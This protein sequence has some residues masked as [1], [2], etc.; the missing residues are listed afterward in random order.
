[1][2]AII[3]GLALFAASGTALARA[4]EPASTPVIVIHAGQLLATAGEPVRD[5][6]TIVVRDGKIVKVVPGFR[7]PTDFDPKA[8]L[9]DLSR[10]FVMAGLSDMHFHFV[11]GDDDNRRSWTLAQRI[12]RL[13]LNAERQARDMLAVG[14]TSVRDVG[15]NTNAVTFQLRDAIDSGKVEGPRLFAAGRLI[16][17]SEGHGAERRAGLSLLSDEPLGGCDGVD[18][19]RRVVRENIGD[20]HG[21]DLIKFTGSGSASE[22]TGARDALPTSSDEEVMAIVDS[23]RRLGRSVAVHAHSTASIDQSLRAGA[24]TIEHGTFFD[25]ETAKLFRLH[26]AFLVPTSFVGDLMLTDPRIK[27]RNTP[28]DWKRIQIIAV[29]QRAN[30]GRGYRAGIRL[31]VGTDS[32]SGL[33]PRNTL[34]EI[35]IFVEDG[36]PVVEALKAATLNNAII[37]GHGVDLGQIKEGFLAD[38]VA[39][40]QSPLQDI[41]ALRGIDFVMKDGIVFRAAA[42]P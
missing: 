8:Q 41:K 29:D 30:A 39:M 5:A 3:A 26:G 9:V 4:D 1:M 13:T 22:T 35:E 23:A 40:P 36:I 15:D 37:V 33:D 38:I 18:S 32:S 19:C 28:E 16:S 10:K 20:G 14:I 42:K 25:D 11:S 2:K 21:A 27:A 12:A 7:P 34:R 17:R 24:L 31:G 6:Q